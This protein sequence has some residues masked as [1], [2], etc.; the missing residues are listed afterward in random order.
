MITNFHKSALDERSI[1]CFELTGHAYDAGIY[2]LDQR[3]SQIISLLSSDV[4]NRDVRIPVVDKDESII[5]YPVGSGCSAKGR[6]SKL[7]IE[8]ASAVLVVDFQL[9]ANGKAA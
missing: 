3:G 5:A 7:G 6:T 2:E 9:S 8:S 4:L 1:T